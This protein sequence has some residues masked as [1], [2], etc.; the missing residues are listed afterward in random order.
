MYYEKNNWSFGPWFQYWNIDRSE[1]VSA[2]IVAGI[3][4]FGFEPENETTEIG[5][6]LGLRF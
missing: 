4:R 5:L 3:E 2:G 6:R 1:T